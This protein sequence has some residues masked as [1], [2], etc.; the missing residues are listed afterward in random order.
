[1]ERFIV[2]EVGTA[3]LKKNHKI[4]PLTNWNKYLHSGKSEITANI[5]NSSEKV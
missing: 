5:N 2:K 4:V 1:V 3:C